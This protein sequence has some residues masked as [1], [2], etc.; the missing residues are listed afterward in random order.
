VAPLSLETFLLPPD[1]GLTG[2]D[3]AM[4][5]YR[6]QSSQPITA[7]QFNPLS[8]V[9]VFSNDA[10]VLL[11]LSSLGKEYFVATL[12]Q[13]SDDFRGYFSIA[14]TTPGVTQVT[15]TPRTMTEPGA[16]IPLLVKNQP[17]SLS[18]NFGEVVVIQSRNVGGD[19][20]GSRIV[21]DKAVQVMAGH[22]AAQTSDSCCA[23]HL[24]QQL[25]PVSTWGKDYLV[26]R[27]VERGI[28]PDYIRVVAAYD[29]TEV[30]LSP[31]VTV[32]SSKILQR[33]DM[34]AFKTDTHLRV[35]ANKPIMVVQ[36][37]ASSYETASTSGI[38][39][40]AGDCPVGYTCKEGQCIPAACATEAE[41]ATGHVCSEGVCVPMGDPAMIL[42]VPVEQWQSSYVFLTPDSY[43]KDYVNIVLPSGANVE[44]DGSPVAV[45]ALEEITGSGYWVYRGLVADGTHRVTAS[46]PVSIMVYGYDRDVSYGY[47]G[48][49]GLATIPP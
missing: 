34:W 44:I 1:F 11:P 33:G 8:N 41:C 16:D 35:I 6:I 19:L 31:A 36:F 40:G 47:P 20:T 13:A 18:L 27:S 42:A 10:S 29:N 37:L 23:D 21:A 28:E 7:Y 32:P 12:P 30:S 14:A 2:T 24:E 48:G 9:G 43:A 38:C 39:F 17:H 4:A 3:R 49:L 5:A 45:G 26:G 15:V 22:V 25:A 46:H